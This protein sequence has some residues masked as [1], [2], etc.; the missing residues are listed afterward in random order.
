MDLTLQVHNWCG[1]LGSGNED[2]RLVIE[3]G[4]HSSLNGKNL[5]IILM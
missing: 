1:C 2:W 4:P 3:A 5:E